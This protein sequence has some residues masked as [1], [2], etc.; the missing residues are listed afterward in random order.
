M[1]VWLDP[2]TAYYTLI[3]TYI[4]GKFM[5]H[6]FGMIRCFGLRPMSAN[7]VNFIGRSTVCLI[8]YLDIQYSTH[9]RSTLPGIVSMELSHE[10]LTVGKLSPYHYF[11]MKYILWCSWDILLIWVIIQ[12]K[13]HQFTSSTTPTYLTVHFVGSVASCTRNVKYLI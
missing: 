8:V 13:F 4:F 6:V 9:K 1:T 10:R 5:I 7:F 3:P 12:R 11:I 2:P